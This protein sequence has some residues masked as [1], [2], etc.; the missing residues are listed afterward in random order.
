MNNYESYTPHIDTND[1]PPIITSG[2]AEQQDKKKQNQTSRRNTSK[3]KQSKGKNVTNKAEKSIIE[4]IKTFVTSP[5]L[6][7]ITGIFLGCLAVYLLISFLSYFT[8]CIKDQAVINSTPVGGATRI[9]N[10]GGEGGARLSE[11]LINRSFG[12][13]SFVIIVWLTAMSMKLLIGRPHFKSVNFTIKCFVALITVSLIVGISSVITNTYVNWGGYHAHYVYEFINSF[14]GYGSYILCL[15]MVALFVLICLN[16]LV[17]WIRKKYNEQME[18]RRLAAEEKA[19][20]LA[21][22]EALLRDEQAEHFDDIKAGESV[23]LMGSETNDIPE[24]DTQMSFSDTYVLNE[25]RR[26]SDTVSDET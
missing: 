20:R 1:E 17:T 24:N 4:R 14:L 18:R 15:F 6:R 25:D 12:I 16:D 11:F 2:S 10:H 26:L 19:A 5:A 21:R 13:G 22:E 7:Q 3:N 23:T 8:A 9:A